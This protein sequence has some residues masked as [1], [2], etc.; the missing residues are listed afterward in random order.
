MQQ[1]DSRRSLAGSFFM[2][3]TSQFQFYLIYWRSGGQKT[4][5]LLI[6]IMWNDSLPDWYW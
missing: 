4:A 6:A 3:L 5:N 1:E 2:F